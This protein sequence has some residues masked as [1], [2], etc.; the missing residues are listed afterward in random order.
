M[1][2]FQLGEFE[3]I[4]LLTIGILHGEAYSVSIKKEIEERL[5]RSVSLGGLHTALERLEKK[6]Y[7]KSRDGDPTPDRAGRPKRYVEVTALGI[8]AMEYSKS[9]RDSLWKALPKGVVGIRKSIR[10]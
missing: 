4:V 10:S 9:T 8:K 5:S 7:I 2:K 6:G 1:K 3:E